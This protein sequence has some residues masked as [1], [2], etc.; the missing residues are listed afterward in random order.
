ML[1][2]LREG[3]LVY[4]CVDLYSLGTDSSIVAMPWSMWAVQF[5]TPL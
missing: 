3:S 4:R 1:V 5:S 2:S